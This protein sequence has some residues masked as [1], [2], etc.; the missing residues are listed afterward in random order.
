MVNVQGKDNKD[1]RGVQEE[2]DTDS[3]HDQ[4]VQITEL[5]NLLA[6]HQ[7]I[8]KINL[9]RLFYSSG[10]LDF[11]AEEDTILHNVWLGKLETT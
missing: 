5:N 3:K 1:S 4:E 7:M 9:V 2:N 8:S 6:I 11:S 10:F